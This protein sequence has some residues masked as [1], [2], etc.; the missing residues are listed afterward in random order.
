MYY[1]FWKNGQ[2]VDPCR[3]VMPSAEPLAQAEMPAF[4]RSRNS[5]MAIMDKAEGRARHTSVATF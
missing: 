3:E 2:Q 5:L 1:R 4:H